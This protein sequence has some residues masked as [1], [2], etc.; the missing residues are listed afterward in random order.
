MLRVSMVTPLLLFG[1][2]TTWA[3]APSPVRDTTT[4]P[5]PTPEPAE[6]IPACPTRWFNDYT[7][8]TSPTFGA[9]L[10]ER[11]A[12]FEKETTNQF[13]VVIIPKMGGD[14]LTVAS[15]RIKANV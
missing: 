13:I 3:Q 6:V 9:K 14:N 15:D 5:S 8:A 1:S 4:I 11:L 7:K 10:D 2:V 12:R